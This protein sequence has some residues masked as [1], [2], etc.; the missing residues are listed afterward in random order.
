MRC[1]CW[2]RLT[3][4]FCY[5]PDLS[6]V[7]LDWHDGIRVARPIRLPPALRTRIGEQDGLGISVATVIRIADAY[8]S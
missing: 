8:R 1:A 7:P 4:L 2:L 5:S 3:Y 6:P